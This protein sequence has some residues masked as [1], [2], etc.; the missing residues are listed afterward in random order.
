M[1]VFERSFSPISLL[2][3]L[4]RRRQEVIVILASECSSPAAAAGD[5]VKGSGQLRTSTC[6]FGSALQ[7]RVTEG[8]AIYLKTGK[9]FAQDCQPNVNLF[10][11][12]HIRSCLGTAPH[13]M[14]QICLLL[15]KTAGRNDVPIFSSLQMWI[16]L[17]CSKLVRSMFR[18]LPA[19]PVPM[20]S[21]FITFMISIRFMC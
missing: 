21:A 5:N 6:H 12:H 8:Q 13:Q 10:C 7:A 9:I 20:K 14:T 15:Q 11:A 18:N 3:I 4:K 2:C 16:F 17:C 19:A 1:Q